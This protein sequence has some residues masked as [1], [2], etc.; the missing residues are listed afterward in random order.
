MIGTVHNDCPLTG[1]FVVCVVWM[2]FMSELYNAYADYLDRMYDESDDL[3][4]VDQFTIPRHIDVN[5][6]IMVEW[7]DVA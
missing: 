3:V 2:L 6:P 7:A 5:N 1:A 4:T